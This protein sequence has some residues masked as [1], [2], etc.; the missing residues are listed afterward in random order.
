MPIP[1]RY[2]KSG[3]GVCEKADT[4][5]TSE[6]ETTINATPTNTNKRGDGA[7][8]ATCKDSGGAASDINNNQGY[9]YG[10]Q[11]YSGAKRVDK[12]AVQKW[13][14]DLASA[15]HDVITAKQLQA[16]LEKLEQSLRDDGDVKLTRKRRRARLSRQSIDHNTTMH[17]LF[18][19]EKP[20]RLVELSKLGYVH[21]LTMYGNGQTHFC[22]V[23]AETRAKKARFKRS[24]T[25]RCAT[26]GGRI[27]S[28][29]KEVEERSY[30]GRKYAVCFIDDKTRYAKTYYLKHKSDAWLAFRR[31]IEEECEPRDIVVQRLRIDG[32]TEYGKS[33]VCYTQFSEFKDYLRTKPQNIQIK[34]ERSPAFCQS[35]NGVSER[36]WQTLFNIVR[37]I[38]RDQSRSKKLWTYAAELAQLIHNT[39]T[40]VAVTGTTPYIAWHGE[41][42]SIRD[43]KWI[44]PLSDVWAFVYKDMGRGTLD[45]VRNKYIFV[46]YS[47][48]SPCYRLFNPTTHTV[49]ERRYADCFFRRTAVRGGDSSDGAGAGGAD[50]EGDKDERTDGDDA[51]GSEVDFVSGGDVMQGATV[52]EEPT[53]NDTWYTNETASRLLRGER[54]EA[55]TTADRKTRRADTNVDGVDGASVGSNSN[56]RKWRDGEKPN[57]DSG[58]RRSRRESKGKRT[59]H[60]VSA[61]H[62]S[63]RVHEYAFA[64]DGQEWCYNTAVGAIPVPRGINQAMSPDYKKHWYAAIRA[65][66]DGCWEAECFKWVKYSDVPAQA[67]IMN[68]VW[69]FKVKPDRLKA[70]ACVNGKQEST[71]SYDDIYSPVCKHTTVRMLLWQCVVN[72]WDLGS[73]DVNLAYLNSDNDK[74]Q[75]CH[76]PPQLGKPGHCLKLLK[77]L[78]GLH[79]SGLRWHELVTSWLTSPT[80]TDS[81][82]KASKRRRKRGKDRTEAGKQA[83]AAVKEGA[84]MTQSKADECLFYRE[85]NGKRMYVVLYVDDLLYAGDKGMI[86]E[87]KKRLQ[88]RFKVRHMDATDYLGLEIEYDRK[89]GTMKVG[90]KRYLQKILARFGMERCQTRKTPMAGDYRKKLQKREGPC[91]DPKRQKLYRQICGSL[92]FLSVSSRP[93]ISFACKE[94][95]RHLLNPGEAHVQAGLRVL[96][97]LKHTE[98]YCL[99]YTRDAKAHFY[100]HADADFAGEDETAKSTTGFGFSGG[101]GVLSW[102][103]GSQSLVSH[104]STESELIALD[105]A[106]RE[107]EYLRQ[108]AADFHIELELPIKV[109]QDNMSTIRIVEGGR[110]TS[111]TKHISVRYHYT[112]NLTKAS[113]EHPGGVLVPTYLPTKSMPSDVLTKALGSEDHRRHTLVL[114]GMASLEGVC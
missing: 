74:D 21:G 15:A 14:S 49:V 78:Y 84:G 34:V 27:H 97:Y 3:A 55:S 22:E 87:F 20:E 1:R 42:P 100:G 26:A 113:P 57:D 95:S 104:S 30:G 91:D 114:L 106:A 8:G 64:V 99:T 38:L 92:M 24:S 41:K 79:A 39:E 51:E 62:T 10:L 6:V 16:E 13:A 69:Q 108:V 77:M 29:L 107:L 33:G 11:Y 18:G 80:S 112:H 36:Y 48:E 105:S 35:M 52:E 2:D 9:K 53:V 109:Y 7:G 47:N 88:N 45:K 23:C 71:D 83:D 75:Y 19:H 65:E 12:R 50:A 59:P 32:G 73:S 54:S 89:A 102:K 44:R 40:T 85:E 58:M 81:T 86:S 37:S 103:A 93:D 90:Q 31:F 4:T 17:E 66:W 101:S 110:F 63:D 82:R 98:D 67:V 76:A 72:G 25:N 70:R 46:G 94:L 28:D 111:R 43:P 60:N 96:R 61:H 5:H 68:L 56:K